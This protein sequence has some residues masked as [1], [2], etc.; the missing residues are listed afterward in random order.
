MAL[1]DRFR[2]TDR[3]ALVTG[4]GRG[5]GQAIALAFAEMGAHVVCAALVAAL[6][7]RVVLLGFLEATSIPSNNALYLSPVVPLALAFP[8]CVALLARSLWPAPSVAPNTNI[9]DVE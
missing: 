9:R 8:F 5:I 7:A 6:S 1:L 2:L 4:A 3:V